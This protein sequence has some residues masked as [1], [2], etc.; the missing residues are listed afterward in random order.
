MFSTLR[1]AF[2]IKE[3]RQKLLFTFLMLVVIRLGSSLPIPGV[4]TNY[5]REFFAKQSG[6]AFGFFNA[7]TGGSFEQ[8]SVLASS[9]GRDAKRWR[10]RKKK[11]CGVY[12]I[13]HGGARTH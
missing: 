12:K 10:R 6:D 7:M 1:N 2:K 5:F 13:C 3:L 4:N 8:M 11:D 9:I